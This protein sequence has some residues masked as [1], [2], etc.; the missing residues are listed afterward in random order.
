MADVLTDKRTSSNRELR[1]DMRTLYLAQKTELIGE[2][3]AALSSVITRFD[4]AE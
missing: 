3:T 4:T 1:M 2:L